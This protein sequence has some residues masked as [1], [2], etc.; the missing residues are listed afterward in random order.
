MLIQGPLYVNRKI[1]NK[2]KFPNEDNSY[3]GGH[4]ENVEDK[5]PS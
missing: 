4:S 2:E 3:I 1:E 5:I